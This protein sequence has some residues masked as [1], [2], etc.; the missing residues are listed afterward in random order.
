P[1]P[2]LQGAR[3]RDQFFGVA[4][5]QVDADAPRPPARVLEAQGATGLLHGP[6]RGVERAPA[7]LEVG[8]QAR[9]RGL[10]P[11]L[12]EKA[13]DGARGDGQQPGNLWRTEA[14]LMKAQD[15][16]T[17]LRRCGSRHEEAPPRERGER[18]AGRSEQ[19]WQSQAKQ[20]P[21]AGLKRAAP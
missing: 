13:S 19:G 8:P 2:K 10:L 11:P 4:L 16:L 6:A 9:A 21:T 3:G 7:A 14:L 20:E 1:Q 18:Q 5:E 12:P 15:A 17:R